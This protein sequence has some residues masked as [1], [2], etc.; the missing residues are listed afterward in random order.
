[1]PRAARHASSARLRRDFRPLRIVFRLLLTRLRRAAAAP[2][3]AQ[4]DSALRWAVMRRPAFDRHE[5]EAAHAAFA[6]L[7]RYVDL[8]MLRA[9]VALMAAL[10]SHVPLRAQETGAVARQHHDSHRS[11]T[12][13]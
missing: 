6:F 3:R 4:V 5:P 2:Q 11:D 1:M 13:R 7:R 10:F 12:S 9:R 8:P